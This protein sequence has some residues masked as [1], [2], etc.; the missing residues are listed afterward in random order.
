[1]SKSMIKL[2]SIADYITILNVIFGFLSL[3]MI[4]IG[5]IQIAFSLILLAVLAD[6]L[7]GVVARKTKTK[8]LGEYFDSIADMVSF[9]IAPAFFVFSIYYSNCTCFF[10]KNVLIFFVLIIYVSVSIIRLAAFPMMKNKSYF[11]GLPVP[12]S[13]IILIVL[14]YLEVE[15]RVI[16][17][18][19]F[20]ISVL[21]ISNIKFPKLDLKFNIIACL[22][23][24]LTL[25]FDKEFEG[26][27][28]LVLLIAIAFYVAFGPIYLW[29]ND[30]KT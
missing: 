24:L 7:D 1:M 27:A 8:S 3:T 30:K 14:A 13:S 25:V 22:L 23:I 20:I 29:V 15:L 10:N 11:I 18:A 28:P 21:M 5:E 4:F 9:G 17:T 26:T 6:G 19:V 2:L 12:S 16:L